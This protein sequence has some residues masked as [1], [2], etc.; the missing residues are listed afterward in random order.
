MANKTLVV[1]KREYL[2]RVRSK[3]FIIATILGPVFLGLITV[4]PVVLASKTKSS[5]RL[6][7]VVIIDASGTG[8]G[9]RI[10]KTLASFTPKAPPPRVHVVKAEQVASE[11]QHATQQVIDREAVGY[12]V[13]DSTTTAGNS[14]RYAGRNATSLI[15]VEVIERTVQQAVL[16]QRLEAEGINGARVSMLT[17]IKIDAKTQKIT[18]RGKENASGLASFFFGYGVALV[19]YMMIAIYGQQIMRGVLEEKTNRVAEVVVSSVKPDSLLAGKILGAGSVALTQVIAWITMSMLMY[20]VRAPLLK[21]F[22][23]AGAGALKIPSVPA[24][25][26]VALV[27]FFVLG[28]ILYAAL[29]CAVGAMVSN[30]EDVQQAATPVMMLLIA[31]IIFMQPVLLNPSSTLATVVSWLPFTAPIMM[32]LRMSLIAIPWYEIVGSLVSVAL[33]CWVATWLS[34][35]IY[36][37]GLLMYGKKPDMKEL[38]RWI[39]MA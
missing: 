6:S 7:D 10:G 31:S 27:L 14:M 36:R 20:Q 16:A 12:I 28:F 24:L 22:G 9:A 2:E 23:V 25:V 30:Q 21:A 1:F 34:A 38:A 39:R 13:L 18:D 29:F 8:L 17:S 35:R 3:W 15:D 33:G 5:D 19:L 32:P 37:V 11:E 4:V 26:G